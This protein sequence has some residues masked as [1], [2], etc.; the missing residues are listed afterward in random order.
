MGSYRLTMTS[1][2]LLIVLLVSLAS[3][4]PVEQVANKAASPLVNLGCQCSRLQY[5]DSRGVYRGHCETI[6]E[7]QA[8]WC[9]V[10][11]PSTCRDL[12]TSIRFPSR[13]WS[14]EACAT[15]FP[16]YALPPSDHYHVLPSAPLVVVPSHTHQDSHSHHIQE[17]PQIFGPPILKGAGQDKEAP[18]K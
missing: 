7:T 15:S 1:T 8:R 17:I 5:L 13:Y 18:T 12:R 11:H 6:D 3:A 14:Y 2:N 4:S 10:D 16:T 9:Y